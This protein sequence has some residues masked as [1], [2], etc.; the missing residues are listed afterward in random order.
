VVVADIG[1]TN[2]RFALARSDADGRIHLASLK[3]Y[4]CVDFL[5]PVALLKR[6]LSDHDI[7]S[8]V[9]CIL[10]CAAPITAGDVVAQANLPW[11]LRHASFSEVH[12]AK[13]VHLVNDFVALAYGVPTVTHKQSMLLCG[14]SNTNKGSILVIGPGTGLGAA[15]W[16]PGSPSQVLAS[17]AGHSALAVVSDDEI[18]LLR[19]LR[20]K[21]PHVDNER[22]LSGP[23]ICNTYQAL[24]ESHGVVARLQ[25][26]A[27]IT[28]AAIDKTDLM[29]TESLALFCG[30]LGSVVAD[31]AIATS[32]SEVVLAG[33]IPIQIL[34]FLRNSEFVHR[35]Q[36]K[37]VMTP[38]MKQIPVY[39]VDHGQLALQGAA[40]WFFEQESTC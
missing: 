33:G 34:P 28:T 22:V 2:A 40:Q 13:S 27:E 20:K 19:M 21:W 10:A 7:D 12:L 17:E 39:V 25:T 15:I 38:L 31:L 16:L 11:P 37:G 32:A 3:R 1:G 24:C 14:E 35:F 30:L 29:A 6:Y 36:S 26:P 8:V 18:N 4:L 5:S 9:P 23:G